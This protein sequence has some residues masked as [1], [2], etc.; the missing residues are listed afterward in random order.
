MAHFLTLDHNP[1]RYSYLQPGMMDDDDESAAIGEL[2]GNPP[3]RVLYF[4]FPESEILRIWPRTDPT[5]LRLRRIETYLATNYHRLSSISYG[6][7]SFEI[8]EPDGRASGQ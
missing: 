2:K 1:T 8:L 7:G 5:R 4:D 6:Q 3:E